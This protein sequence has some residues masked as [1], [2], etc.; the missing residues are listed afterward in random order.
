MLINSHNRRNYVA[1]V[2]LSLLSFFAKADLSFDSLKNNR[3]ITFSY[4][5]GEFP[6][7]YTLAGKPTGIAV[8]LCKSVAEHIGKELGGKLQIKWIKV[9]PAARFQSLINH[10]SDIECSNITNTIERQKYLLFSVPYFYASTTFMSHKFSH[11][12]SK[13]VLSGH[14]VFVTSGDIAVQALAE[15]NNKLSHSLS[16]HLTQSAQ[17]GFELLDSSNNSVFV[18]DD[19]LL[20][21]LRAMCSHP[22]EYEISNDNLLDAQPFALALPY[23]SV[24]LHKEV[25]NAMLEI[26]SD[27]E[28]S[29]M[30]NK[31]FLSSI[32]P[33]NIS[34]NMPMSEKLKQDMA[35]MSNTS[36]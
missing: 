2:F 5:D 1:I 9:P 24:D 30:Y 34:I 28:F 11:I 35:K 33:Y 29:K 19:V 14:T 12:S 17:H 7:S 25:N 10:Q 15:L 31:W 21:S 8:D 36:N 32:S 3:V 18:A 26:F 6:F 16:I 13:K 22:E 20:Y 4:I 27:G 23:Q